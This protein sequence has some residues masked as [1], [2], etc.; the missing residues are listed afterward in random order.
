MEKPTKANLRTRTK[1]DMDFMIGVM[2]EN[3][4]DGGTKISNMALAFILIKDP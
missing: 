2:V 3:T 1:K 4:K